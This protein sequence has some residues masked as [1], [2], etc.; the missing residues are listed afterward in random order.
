MSYQDS[1]YYFKP[2]LFRDFI[3][4]IADKTVTVSDAL[5]TFREVKCLP[6]TFRKMTIEEISSTPQSIQDLYN[7]LKAGMQPETKPK[8]PY[9]KAERE[10]ELIDSLAEQFDIDT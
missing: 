8:L 9:K 4:S 5:Y 10:Q 1:I 6:D 3:R 2:G 7:T